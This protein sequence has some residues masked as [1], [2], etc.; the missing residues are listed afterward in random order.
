MNPVKFKQANHLSTEYRHTGE[1]TPVHIHKPLA[2][3][4]TCWEMGLVERFICLFT[5]KVFISNLQFKKSSPPC[6]VGMIFPTFTI[7]DDRGKSEAN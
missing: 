1:P 5:G 4:T 2:I 7:K 6:T 3:W